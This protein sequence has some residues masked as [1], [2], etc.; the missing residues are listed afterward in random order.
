MPHKNEPAV[1]VKSTYFKIQKSLVKVLQ[2]S[3]QNTPY[4]D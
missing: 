2:Q 3:P 4:F 1:C